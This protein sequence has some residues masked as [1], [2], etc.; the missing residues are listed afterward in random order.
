M[1][2][3]KD[4]NLWTLR[5]SLRDRGKRIFAKLYDIHSHGH[6][7]NMPFFASYMILNVYD[8]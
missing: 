1:C 7:V 6:C 2:F 8:T 3:I 4:V 5:Y